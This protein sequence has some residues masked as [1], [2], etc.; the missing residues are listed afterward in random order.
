MMNTLPQI[1]T[2][3]SSQ[4]SISEMNVYNQLGK[5][6]DSTCCTSNTTDYVLLT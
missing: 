4:L 2:C 6:G 5:R 1:T 3:S